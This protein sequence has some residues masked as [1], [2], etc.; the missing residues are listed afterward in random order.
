MTEEQLDSHEENVSRTVSRQN[1]LWQE[2][3][4]DA[5]IAARVRRI[6]GEKNAKALAQ[7]KRDGNV[8]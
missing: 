3:R 5:G 2:S 8:I 4:Q 7:E 1:R 6:D